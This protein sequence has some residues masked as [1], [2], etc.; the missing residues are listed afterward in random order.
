MRQSCV[1]RAWCASVIY[2]DASALSHNKKRPH[3]ENLHRFNQSD[4]IQ[5]SCHSHIPGKLR[6][7][8]ARWQRTRICTG[9]P[10]LSLHRRA[11][12]H[13]AGWGGSISTS[14]IYPLSSIL[15]HRP[16]QHCAIW[17]RTDWMNQV[18]HPTGNATTHRPQ[19]CYTKRKSDCQNVL[20]NS[21]STQR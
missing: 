1:T 3:R 2:A 16:N 15:M 17:I 21:I 13:V 20:F 4:L 9:Q 19:D 6:A 11:H 8:D 7:T 10:D 12:E 14:S 5:C 18:T